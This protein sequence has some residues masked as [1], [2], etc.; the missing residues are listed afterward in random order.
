MKLVEKE[1]VVYNT[2]T[3]EIVMQYAYDSELFF[4]L[5]ENANNMN[6]CA[7]ISEKP[8]TFYSVQVIYGVDYEDNKNT[9]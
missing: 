8:R 6:E 9:K 4:K 1:I 3:K 2:Y 7:K 5:M